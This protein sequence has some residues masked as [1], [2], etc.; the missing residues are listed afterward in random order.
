MS[1]KSFSYVLA[2]GSNLNRDR[3]KRRCPSS[4]VVGTAD[5]LGYRILFKKSMTGAYATIEQDA[6]WSVPAVV[7]RI[8]AAD[9]IRLDR[10]EGCPTYYYKHHFILRIR[11]TNGRKTTELCSAYI[12]HEDRLLGKPDMDYFRLIDQGYAQYGFDLSVLDEGLAASIGKK[13]AEE[14]IRKYL[15]QKVNREPEQEGS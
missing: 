6:N 14:Y 4:R 13:A 10:F 8:N 3:M 15:N 5:I 9:E 1:N 2:Y 12:M 7:Y 11:R